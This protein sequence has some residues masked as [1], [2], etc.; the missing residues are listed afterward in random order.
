MVYHTTASMSLTVDYLGTPTNLHTRTHTHTH[1]HR[2][3]IR[4]GQWNMY[5]TIKGVEAGEGQLPQIFKWGGPRH[6]NHPTSEFHL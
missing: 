6:L 1:T 4:L 2:K 3:E 5:A